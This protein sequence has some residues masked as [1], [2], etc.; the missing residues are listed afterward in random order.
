MRDRERIAELSANPEMFAILVR[1]AYR[2]VQIQFL[3]RVV[4]LAFM[5]AVIGWE[6]PAHGRTASLFLVVGYAVWTV[7]VW[8]WTRQGGPAPVR[9]MWLVL[10]VDT[11]ALGA[12][13]LIAGASSAE[14]SWTADILINGLFLVPA[15]AATQ[16]RPRVCAAVVIP[17]TVVYFVASL[18]TKDANGEPWSSVILRTFVMAG[19]SAAG[20]GLSRVQLLRV[21]SIAG[22]ARDRTD[23]LAD[24]T[25]AESSTRA[26]LAE[27]LHDGAL[28][29]VLGRPAGSRGSARSR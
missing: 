2:G 28:Q 15:L 17:A 1:N 3:L 20:V 5:V 14:Q 19:L 21:Y 8:A 22:L 16:L 23:L 13:V 27:D 26:R 7:A 25:N 9:W 24:L 4:L 12:L 11:L 10:L 18:F 29:Y 6:P